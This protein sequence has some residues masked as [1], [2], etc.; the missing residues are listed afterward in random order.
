[1]EEFMQLHVRN[2]RRVKQSEPVLKGVSRRLGEGKIPGSE[3]PEEPCKYQGSQIR[4]QA[5][6]I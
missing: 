2:F 5:R 1:V 4:L 3:Q 6:K